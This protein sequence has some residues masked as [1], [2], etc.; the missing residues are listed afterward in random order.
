MVNTDIYLSSYFLR[1]LLIVNA[2]AFVV[3]Q[4][5]SSSSIALMDTPDRVLMVNTENV[6]S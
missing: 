6:S 5:T 3:S 2:S 4:G 1:F